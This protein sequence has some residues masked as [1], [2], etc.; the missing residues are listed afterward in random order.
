[1]KRAHHGTVA[2][3]LA[4]RRQILYELLLRDLSADLLTETAG[5]LAH[6]QRNRGIVLAQI[7]MS[8]SRVHDDE[9]VIL[10]AE[11]EVH[12]LP[13]R[14]RR[15]LEVDGDEAADR[16]GHL[17][18][19]AG[20]LVPVHV[21][22]V[23][24]DVGVGHHVDGAVV[25]EIVHHGADE[26]LVGRGG[27]DARRADDV[28]GD[29]GVEASHA[30][31]LL[32]KSGN[33]TLGQ[34]H[35]ARHAVA[36][37]QIIHRKL[38]VLVKRLADDTDDAGVRPSGRCHAVQVNAPRQDLSVVVVRVVSADLR[39][40]RR[41]EKHHIAVAVGFGQ[42]LHHRLVAGFILLSRRA[43]ELLHQCAG[44]VGFQYLVCLV[45]RHLFS[46]LEPLILNYSISQ[47]IKGLKLHWHFWLK[48]VDLLGQTWYSGT[49]QSAHV[50]PAPMCINVQEYIC[51]WNDRPAGATGPTIH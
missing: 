9:A 21:L 30:V 36:G 33:Q 42:S 11:I 16:A 49:E 20:R 1:M 32:L 25:V 43:V 2:R 37:L 40:S 47:R 10:R 28:A 3:L 41:A 31:S 29:V 48:P 38:E 46:S 7:R 5:H 18:Q 34:I 8:L 19:Q 4:D 51:I 45:D 22:R 24:S 6:L 44:L 27:A 14:S 15:I 35:R 50:Q 39:S 12:L 23:F 26:H 17:V 13:R